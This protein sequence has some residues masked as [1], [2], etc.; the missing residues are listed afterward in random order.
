MKIG[1]EIKKNINV[2]SGI[3]RTNMSTKMSSTFGA[4]APK[5]FIMNKGD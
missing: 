4:K 5:C 1:P 2:E 3:L